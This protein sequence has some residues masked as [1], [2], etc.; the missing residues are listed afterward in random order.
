M[1]GT[2]VGHELQ[3]CAKSSHRHRVGK[4]TF[5]ISPKATSMDH[6]T[7]V[8]VAD[9]T[10]HVFEAAD[11]IDSMGLHPIATRRPICVRPRR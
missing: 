8:E 4:M 5:S 10:S 6:Q 1:S 3:P 2:A 11:L 7:D 9:H